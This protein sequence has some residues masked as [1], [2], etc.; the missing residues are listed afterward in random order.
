MNIDEQAA[1]NA[2]IYRFAQGYL[3]KRGWFASLGG[4]PRNNEGVVPW[5]TYPAYIQLKR[6]I[7]PDFKVFEYG[8]GGSS[9]WWANNVAAV[10]SVEHDK[11]WGE[12]VSNAAQPNLTVIV[13]E[14]GE[15]ADAERIDAVAPFFAAPPELPL[16]HSDEHNIMHGLISET[17]IAYATEI[18]AFPKEYFDV[19][20]VDGMA[21]ALSAW[22]AIQY[23]KPGGIIVFDNS[24]RWQ[25]NGAYRMLSAAGFRRI[26]Y[27]G[28]GPVNKIEWCT[29]L[30]VR[31]L[32]VFDA[33]IDSP[34]GD[35]DL[36]W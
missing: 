4:I 26:D 36:G 33:S 21:R 20:V 27:Y 6:I 13:R 29:S 25:Y 34:H 7:R 15:A 35:C 28:P 16:S 30:F 5:I 3:Q 8:C 10:T 32:N 22:M 23:L 17:F 11:A 9:L 31:D 12:N 24:D 1:V 14:M 19:I 18:M 2:D